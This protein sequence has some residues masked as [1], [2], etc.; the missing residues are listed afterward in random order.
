MLPLFAVSTRIQLFLER[1]SW[2]GRNGSVVI[3]ELE[4][5]RPS[6]RWHDSDR[7][8]PAAAFGH[9]GAAIRQIGISFSRQGS[10]RMQRER[11]AGMATARGEVARSGFNDDF[12]EFSRI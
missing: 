7:E 4:A 2:I 12:D 3:Y 8:Y 10:L 6:Y 11:S 5:E 9:R 1:R